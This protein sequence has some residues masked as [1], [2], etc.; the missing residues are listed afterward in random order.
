MNV[1]SADGT[2]IAYDK[3]GD[4]PALVLVDGALCRRNFGPS[5]PLAKE[6]ADRF[7][8]Y[9]YDRRG[10]GESGDTPPY[11][12]DR[13]LEDLEAVI[14]EAGGSAF[15]FG[16]SSGAALALAAAANGA[17]IEKLALYEAPFV[18]DQSRDP[19]PEDIVAQLRDC[20]DSERRGDA[21]RLF[22]QQVGAPRVVVSVMRL[23][24]MW[25]KL[26]AVAHTLP[27]DLTVVAGKQQGRPL[28]ADE[29]TGATM[30]TLSLVGGKSPVW[31]HN[32]MRA[33]A[34]AVS[35]A[36]YD[37]LP[38]QTHMVR[39]KALAPRLATFLAAGTT[40]GWMG[41]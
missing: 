21:V 40:V 33:L 24:P 34:G 26:T 22:M 15:A 41:G 30:P 23:T 19:V 1:H 11:A 10:R 6:L 31:L 8:V 35:N 12:V 37:V 20:V 32:G 4:G 9:T 5:T 39:A 18:V 16:I 25:S 27:Y 28:L 13:E 2:K 14:E 7:T 36:E 29:W 38:G 3:V 17:P